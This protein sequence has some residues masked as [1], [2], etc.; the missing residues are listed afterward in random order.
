MAD[1]GRHASAARLKRA[2]VHRT[3]QQTGTLALLFRFGP[4]D[5]H[6]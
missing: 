5:L 6:A 4:K 1:S 3:L 2:R